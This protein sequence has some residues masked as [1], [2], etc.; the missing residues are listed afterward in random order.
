MSLVGIKQKT[1]SS[2]VWKLFERA[3]RSIVELVIQLVLAHLLLPEQ[4]GMLAIMLVFINIGNVVVQ[5]GLNTALVQNEETSDEDCSTVFWMSLSLSLALYV[6]FFLLAP[7]IAEF[8]RISDLVWPLRILCL[9]L[10]INAYNAVQVAIV[11]RAL[12]LRKV[13]YATIASVGVSGV[14]GIGSALCGAG[15]WALVV[16]QL[17]YQ[18]ISCVVL[19]MQ[20]PWRPAWVFNSRRALELFAFGWKLLVS[21]LVDAGYRSLSD[22]VIGK[23]FNATALG[24]T[25]QGQRY[26]QALGYMLDGAIQPVM[27]AAVSHVQKDVRQVK[28]LVRRALKTST[29]LVMPI[30]ATVA[31]AAD[32]L[33]QLL[34]GSQWLPCV[35]FLQLYCLNYALLP[36]HTSNLQALNGMG[37]SDVFLKLEIIKKCYGL[38][39]LFLA[40]FVIED[41]YAIVAAGLLSSVIGTFVNA[42]PNKRVINYGYLE[43]LKDVAP[44]LVLTAASVAVAYPI[45][46]L[47]LNPFVTIFLQVSAMAFVYLGISRAIHLEEFDYLVATAKQ[48]KA[49]RQAG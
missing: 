17:S 28:R 21:G 22:L 34:L 19:A 49:G 30:M 29:Y 12:E 43:Q 32:P 36:I 33:V 2:L 3:G 44:S 13:F 11:Q 20:V 15:I 41:I 23:Q 10:I 24:F 1:L 40:A 9:V 16:Q 27:L 38:A 18:A 25:S 47:S 31:I 37:R 39:F 46:M 26:P 35:P 7:C 14:L 6:L 5:S 42:F 48:I 8:Y 45:P 4:F